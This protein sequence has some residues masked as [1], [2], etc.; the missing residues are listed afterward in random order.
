[1]SPHL[2]GDAVT[3][4]PEAQPAGRDSFNLRQECGHFFPPVKMKTSVAV[5]VFM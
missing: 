5:G 4:N 1:M 2:R 3:V